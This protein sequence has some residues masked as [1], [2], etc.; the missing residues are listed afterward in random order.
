MK[1]RRCGRACRGALKTYFK[2][3]SCATEDVLDT[4]EADAEV[5]AAQQLCGPAT[6]QEHEAGH[7]VDGKLWRKLVAGTT[8]HRTG[9]SDRHHAVALPQAAHCGAERA[10]NRVSALRVLCEMK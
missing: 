10:S 7:H 1:R 9:A 6:S 4:F 5:E 8:P 2:Q 3:R